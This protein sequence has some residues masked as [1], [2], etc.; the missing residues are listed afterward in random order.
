MWQ[1]S[2]LVPLTL[3]PWETFYVI[4]GS[5]A[6]ALTGLQFVVI[7]LGAE[8]RVM[9]GEKE[10]QAFGTPTVVHF[11]AVLLT[12]A[13]LSTPGQT[14]T[15]LGACITVAGAGGLVYACWVVRQTHLQ[16]GYAPVL[17]DWIFHAGLPVFSYGCLLVA[18]MISFFH[19]G[20]ALYV[21]AVTSLLLLFIGI[22]NAWDAA[23]YMSSRRRE[24][25]S[26][27]GSSPREPEE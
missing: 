9:G 4:V 19:P 24:S 10:M 8:A 11:C 6:A 20:S 22:H 15:T 7:A 23:I 21:V 25:V 5:S 17:E 27:G 18:G 26:A 1:T 3:H 2:S 12:A 14:A 16:T 13:I